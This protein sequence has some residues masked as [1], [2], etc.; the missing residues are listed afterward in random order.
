MT[1]PDVT[2]LLVRWRSGDHAA[3]EE[4][5]PVVYDELRRVATRRL[6][7]ERPGHTLAPT[8]LVHEAYARLVDS[9]VAWQDRAHFFAVAAG[10]MRRILVDHAR[11]RSSQKRGGDAARVTLDD[12]LAIESD[13]PEKLLALHAAIERLGDFDARKAQVIE[14]LFFGGLNYNETA[15]ALGVSAAT[16]DRDLR[17][18]KAWLQRE[19]SE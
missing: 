15:E 14:L 11:A 6:R 5:V 8:D 2:Q 17:L 16:V 3:L 10:T 19:L 7:A 18:A 4:L 1:A 12:Q 9:D 13:D